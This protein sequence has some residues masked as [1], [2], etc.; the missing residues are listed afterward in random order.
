MKPKAK[1]KA[2]QQYFSVMLFIALWKVVIKFVPMNETYNI[3]HNS[4]ETYIYF[5]PSLKC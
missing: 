1:Q 5:G 2:I 3:R 4:V